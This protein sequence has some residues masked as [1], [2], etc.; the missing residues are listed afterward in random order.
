MD[1]NQQLCFQ[2]MRKFKYK[3]DRDVMTDALYL[4][5]VKG[6]TMTEVREVVIN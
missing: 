6:K 2:V 4:H 1:N 5:F 3:G